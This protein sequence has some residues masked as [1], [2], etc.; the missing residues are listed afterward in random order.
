MKGINLDPSGRG[1]AQNMHRKSFGRGVNRCPLQYLAAEGGSCTSQMVLRRRSES[2]LR[3][4]RHRTANSV[5]LGI[6]QETRQFVE[7]SLV[8]LS[9]VDTL[10][11]ASDAQVLL[12]SRRRFSE[13]RK[14]RATATFAYCHGFPYGVRP[15]E[16]RW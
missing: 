14:R 12:R 4:H 5:E 1:V 11:L 6:L 8:H 3:H 9:S 15:F 2:L 10:A 7:I 16:R 13:A